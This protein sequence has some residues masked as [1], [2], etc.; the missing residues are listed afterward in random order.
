MYDV[1]TGRI[2]EFKFSFSKQI[3]EKAILETQTIDK[4]RK[5]I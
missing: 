3:T 2:E 1:D 5:S 4:L